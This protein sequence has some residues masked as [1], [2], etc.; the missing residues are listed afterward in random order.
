MTMRDRLMALLI[1]T[2]AAF[3][4]AGG[5]IH[6]REWLDT[7]RNVP[8]SVPGAAVVRVG[9]PVNAAVSLVVAIAL[10]ATLWRWTSQMT[11]VALSAF[12]FEAASLASLILS[13][14]GSVLGWKEPVW[15]DGANQARA[16]E[17]IALVALAGVMA[18]PHFLSAR[19]RFV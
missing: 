11:V 19:R 9:F 3:V 12:A 18:A 4:A 5:F 13:R 14:T 15:T 2:A 1:V 6:L 10:L 7:Y 16:V 8:A 17:I